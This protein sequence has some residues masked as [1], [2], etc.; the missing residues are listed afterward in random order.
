M[1]DNG[2]LAVGRS[3][4]ARGDWV[5]AKAAFETAW[6]DQGSA[7][8]LD[9]L[10]RSLWWLGDAPGALDV[11]SR[12]FAL[13]RREGR[14]HEAAAV[15]IWL[16]RQYA[17]LFHRTAMAEGWVA[18]SRSLVADLADP[19]SLEG[20]MALVESEAAALNLA[21]AHA[22]R[23]VVVARKH[24]DVDLEIVALARLGACRVGT[25]AVAAGWS[26]LQQ[27]MTAAVSGE[28]HDVAYVGEA[29]CTLLEVSGW[30]GDPGMVEPWAQQLA[31]FRSAYAFG[32]LLPL[33]TTSGPDLISAFCT[34]CC[35]GVYLVTGRLDVAE[36][37]LADAVT[38][39]ATTGCRPR[40]LHPVA[41]LA[42]L[43]VLQ[44]R[45]EEA[46]AL[47][48]GFESEW[49]CALVAAALDLVQGRPNRA[50]AGLVAALEGLR[51]ATVVS[52]PLRAQLVDAAL[53]VS[54]L[55]LAA[56]TAGELAEVAVA[57]GTTLHKA[58][59]DFAAG[60]VLLA[61]GDFDASARLRAAARAFAE[62]GAPLAACRA[63]MA[64]ARSLADRDRG[65]A[66]T[67][68]R[69]AL[70][71]FDRMGATSEADQA[72]SFLRGL[73]IKGRTGPRDGVVLSRREQEV[74]S[75]VVE[76]LSNAEIAERLFI[77]VKTAGHHVSNILT[78]L[79]VR[80]RTEATAYAL[81]HPA[82]PGPSATQAAK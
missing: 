56:V 34:S 44:G 26:D 63:R 30:L 31:E 24:R 77:S 25:G 29:L 47:L 75:L 49:E 64:L 9:G 8:A 81:L 1:D 5:A 66:V 42:E 70:Q 69:S 54:D 27:A 10:G 15:G 73:G 4:L 48:V 45:L 7:D 80:S 33:E 2:P 6:N 43:R 22:E 40:C 60:K 13:L 28:G 32:P 19:G 41:R 58:Q 76:G 59:A 12:A 20:W 67:E 65:V 53:A 35:G 68:A 57:T 37:E 62:C 50:V 11:R 21:I 17:G 52:L 61:E 82:A 36:R 55:T 18:R 14:D 78:K 23:A 72:A 46:E 39:L 79:G 38:Q 71:A 16:A 74:L 3:S 51:A